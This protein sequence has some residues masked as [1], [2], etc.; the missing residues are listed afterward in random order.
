MMQSILFLF[1]CGIVEAY[2]AIAAIE[3]KSFHSGAQ[4][5]N[6]EWGG[7]VGIYI[8]EDNYIHCLSPSVKCVAPLLE[9]WPQQKCERNVGGRAPVPPPRSC[10]PAFIY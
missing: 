1:L 9:R 5:G 6:F 4:L 8:W 3:L 10:A 2:E 7:G